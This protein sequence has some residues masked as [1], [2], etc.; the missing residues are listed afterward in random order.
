MTKFNPEKK[1][2]LTFGECL[3]PAMEITDPTDAKQYKD[4]YIK[5]TQH[6]LNKEPH[7]ND[8]TAEQIVNANLGYYAGYYDN[9][10]RLRVEKLFSCSHPVFGALEE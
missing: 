5:Y 10:T 1:D 9:E 4:D 7:K 2:I 6:H 3:K 8:M